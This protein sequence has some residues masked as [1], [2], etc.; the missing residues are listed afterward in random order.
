[1]SLPLS[2]KE[3]DRNNGNL[4]VLERGRVSKG[5]FVSAKGWSKERESQRQ[6][7]K[8]IGKT[9]HARLSV[10]MEFNLH[11]CQCTECA[12]NKINELWTWVTVGK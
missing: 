5:W 4:C 12:V 10:K 8:E 1:M 6:K 7:C 9:V 3:N 2:H 11:V